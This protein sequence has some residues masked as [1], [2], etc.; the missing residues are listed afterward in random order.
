[1][2]LTTETPCM[3]GH[4][5][6][7]GETLGQCAAGTLSTNMA[8]FQLICRAPSQEAGWQ[9]LGGA[10]ANASGA[11]RERLLAVDALW[12]D[13]P[14]AF[15]LV[16]AID[17]LELE[18]ASDSIEA[19]AAS[20]D[21]AAR[22]SAVGGVALYC[23]GRDDLLDKATAEVVDFLRDE[24]LLGRERSALEVGCGNG[25]FLA[26]LAP[27]LASVVGLDVSP[28]MLAQARERCRGR[29]KVEIRQGSGRD[30]GDLASG[31]FDLA[32]AIDSFPYIVDVGDDVV[33]SNIA[34]FHRVL[35][36]RGRLL[37]MNYSYR[38][39]DR[40]DRDDIDRLAGAF[41]FTVRRAGFRPFHYWDGAVYDL[42][43]AE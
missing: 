28:V 23:L 26:A 35:R 24:R 18:T 14:D 1:M 13:T 37:I 17:R 2:T 9:A 10:I 11:G 34:A 30:F 39:D 8:L 20:N 41:G 33:R 31:R 4:D 6:F 25:R 15:D 27:E 21:A 42:E 16:R 36:P 32:L 38:G 3:T 43:K 29:A 19:I 22:L 40:A 5:D 12:R 7:A